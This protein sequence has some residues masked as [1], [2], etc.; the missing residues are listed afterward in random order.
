M[1]DATTDEPVPDSQ[2]EADRQASGLLEE[3]KGRISELEDRVKELGDQAADEVRP[4]IDRVSRDGEAL[5]EAVKRLAA[6][7][8]D[9]WRGVWAQCRRSADT[10]QADLRTAT[11]DLRAGLATSNEEYTEA[12]AEQAKAWKARMDRVNDRLEAA[13]GDARE[14][15]SKQL[16]TARSMLDDAWSSVDSAVDA[17]GDAASDTWESVRS[18]A[19]GAFGAL[20]RTVDDAK[21]QAEEVEGTT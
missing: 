2:E 11:A 21:E 5:N 10:L 15:A 8:G 14:Q 1:S 4:T 3:L 7:S 17:V 12:V 16:S 18:Q 6:A 9:A 19:Q 13:R 20:S